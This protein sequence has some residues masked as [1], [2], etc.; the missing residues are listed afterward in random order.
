[1]IKYEL[2]AYKFGELR[3]GTAEECIKAVQN[4]AKRTEFHY[5]QHIISPF[6]Q[7]MEC[8][9]F[10]LKVTNKG[11]YDKE[12]KDIDG[13]YYNEN[14]YDLFNQRIILEKAG[15][16]YILLKGGDNDD[17]D[18]AYRVALD[19]AKD[20]QKTLSRTIDVFIYN[21]LPYGLHPKFLNREL[22]GFR[23]QEEK[24]WIKKNRFG[25]KKGV[26]TGLIKA[27]ALEDKI[28]GG[29]E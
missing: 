5:G 13:F 16:N 6:G 7:T 26:A 20:V 14:R 2:G 15:I 25:A 8:P 29:I 12:Y 23:C 19:I 17:F 28:I 11:Q 22:R 4:V 24:E 27:R 3:F 18:Q 21:G 9:D 1:M 10:L